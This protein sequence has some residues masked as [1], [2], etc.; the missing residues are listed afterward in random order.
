MKRKVDLTQASEEIEKKGQAIVY[1]Y[2][3]KL[4]RSFFNFKQRKGELSAAAATFFLLLSF[5]PLMLFVL[6]TYTY[7]TGDRG[8]SYLQ[9][10]DALKSN[11]PHIAPWILKSLKKIIK[12]H[13]DG[14]G[15]LSLGGLAI[16]AYGCIGFASTLNYGLFKMAEKEPRGGKI[17]ENVRSILSTILIGSFVLGL[18]YVSSGPMNMTGQNMV[19]W[20][21]AF[22]MGLKSS[23]WQS[24]ATIC[25]FT[26]Y[27]KWLAPIRVRYVDA[28]YGA[29]SF[30][31]LFIGGKSFYWVY[32]KLAKKELIQNYGNFYTLT[33]AVL[34]IYFVH[35]AFFFSATVAYDHVEKRKLK[36]PSNKQLPEIPDSKAA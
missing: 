23:L 3:T 8:E 26:V 1:N 4:V 30:F 34:W 22:Q 14:G 24:I 31:L 25:F 32:L 10:F 18:I 5:T 6:F 28:F 13:M 29:I 9:V 27:Y 15:N 21:K 20:K 17:F 11:F 7:I 2:A 35:L 19:W 36:A 16:L 33:E 12:G